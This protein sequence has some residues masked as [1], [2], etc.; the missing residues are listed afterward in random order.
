MLFRYYCIVD[1]CRTGIYPSDACS[2]HLTNLYHSAEYAIIEID[3]YE[4]L[5]S[6]IV[7]ARLSISLKD[8]YKRS[9]LKYVLHENYK[10][11]FFNI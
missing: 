7:N 4:Q 2:T 9:H 11:E 3:R 1:N 5:I 10:Y 6:R 8:S